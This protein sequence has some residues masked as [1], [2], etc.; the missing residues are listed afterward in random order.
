V[1]SRL[2][3]NR[4]R[5]AGGAANSRRRF[6]LGAVRQRAPRRRLHIP[7][8]RIAVTLVVFA[9]IGGTVYGA[10]WLLLGDT[11]RVRDVTVVGAQIT[12]PFAI[13]RASG[14]GGESLLT[15]DAG[16]AA[17][18][19]AALEGVRDATVHRDWPN[20]VIIDVTEDQAWGYWQVG[21][22]RRL[23]SADGKVLGLA[24]APAEGAPT[25]IEVGPPA[26]AESPLLVEPDRDTVQLVARLSSDSTFKHLRVTPT[27][28]IF[29][30]DRG[31]TVLVEQGP[32]AVFGDSHNYEFK[33]AAWGALLGRIEEQQIDANEIDLRFGKSLVLR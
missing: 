20:G 6:E 2:R 13:V 28:F 26:T 27:G 30:R 32:H 1:F 21:E 10:G 16:E 4:R 33:V 29:R 7:F 22:V 8:R 14:V 19:I 3:G 17:A 24:R 25:I 12:D 15:L 18:R 23:I 9:A 5:A 11:L 31:L